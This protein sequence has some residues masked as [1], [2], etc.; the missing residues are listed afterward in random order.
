MKN[1]TTQAVA[2]NMTKMEQ[3]RTDQK[4]L[5]YKPRCHR[6]DMERPIRTWEASE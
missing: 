5:E 3:N 2:K 1:P 6:D 4:I